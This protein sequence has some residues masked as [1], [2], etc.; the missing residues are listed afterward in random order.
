MRPPQPT[1]ANV[2][3]TLAVVLA[4][5]TG[6]AYAAGLANNSVKSR[7]IATNAVNNR[8]IADN[9]VRAP[10]LANGVVSSRSIGDG[11]VGA[12]DLA[13]GSVGS[14]A[15]ADSSLG[16]GDLGADSVSRSEIKTGGVESAE[17][18]DGT[19][20][21]TDIKEGAISST[22]MTS[23]VKALLFGAATLAVN[24]TYGDVTVSN[25]SWPGGAPDSGAPISATWTQPANTLDVVSG[26]ARVAFP[27]S[28][29]ATASSPG[30]GLDV[31]IVDAS[32]RVISASTAQRTG[33]TNY[34]GNGFWSE[35]TGLPGI[36]YQAPFGS[37]LAATPDNFV[38]Y[39][40][41]PF[42]LSETVTGGS[43]ANRAVRVFL[44]RNSSNC[45]PEVT[46]TRIV[47]Y[48]YPLPS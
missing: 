22:R 32:N 11:A 43:S 5:G 34:N 37:D 9:A 15:V 48:R 35:Q 7:H 36:Q 20:T 21:G 1:Y 27:S 28:C 10:D 40:H 14:R 46:D 19:I 25:S 47:V 16:A 44:R 29:S 42:E 18:A 33:S 12:D 45:T 30:R 17:I 39:I 6:S 26:Y 3:S 31:K 24:R 23:G 38:D 13:T 41:L 8:H 2:M 4:L